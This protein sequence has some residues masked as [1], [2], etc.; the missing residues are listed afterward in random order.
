MLRSGRL[1]ITFAVVQWAVG[2][3]LPATYQ[4]NI[5]LTPVCI[6]HTEKLIV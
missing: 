5:C 2:L 3:Q 6:Y 4:L 1:I